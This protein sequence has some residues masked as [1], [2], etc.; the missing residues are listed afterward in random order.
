MNHHKQPTIFGNIKKNMICKKSYKF[1]KNQIP[2]RFDVW[3]HRLLLSLHLACSFLCNFKLKIYNQC[4]HT[5]II[6]QFHSLRK[7]AFQKRQFNFFQLNFICFYL[8]ILPIIEEFSFF[9]SSLCIRRKCW[10]RENFRLPVFDG[11]TCFEMP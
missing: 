1:I 11:F 3:W 7:Y 10:I 5:K 2:F 9:L 8:W 4:S 6:L